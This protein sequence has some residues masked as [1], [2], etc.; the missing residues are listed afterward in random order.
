MLLHE[1]EGITTSLHTP[2]SES[3]AIITRASECLVS[4]TY[5][6]PSEEEDITIIP[7]DPAT[8]LIN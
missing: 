1:K 8:Q 4:C 2:Y 6:W 3:M 7:S 5:E